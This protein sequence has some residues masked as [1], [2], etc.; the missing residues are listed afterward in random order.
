MQKFQTHVKDRF[1]PLHKRSLKLLKRKYK[2]GKG[3]SSLVVA[4]LVVMPQ[5]DKIK[6]K[7]MKDK[8]VAADKKKAEE[9]AKLSDV[10]VSAAP[11]K[12]EKGPQIK[13]PGNVSIPGDKVGPSAPAKKPLIQ[14]VKKRPTWA[15]LYN[16]DNTVMQFIVT[17]EKETSA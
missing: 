2:N 6:F 11:M 10:K 1:Y 14:V 8:V 17:V 5:H 7:E 16:K 13:M 4:P 15:E 3:T 12:E 9:G